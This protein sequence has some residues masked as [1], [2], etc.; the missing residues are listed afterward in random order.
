MKKMKLQIEELS[1]DSFSTAGT[2]GPLRGTVRGNNTG[3]PG[4][5]A[6]ATHEYPSC[7][8]TDCGQRTCNWEQCYGTGTGGGTANTLCGQ[9]TCPNPDSCPY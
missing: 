5:V 4:C 9:Y 8:H 1:V 6:Y 3:D 2:D 7:Y